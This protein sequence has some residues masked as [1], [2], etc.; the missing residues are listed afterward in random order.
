M[1]PMKGSGQHYLL[2]CPGSPTIHQNTKTTFEVECFNTDDAQIM[3]VDIYTPSAVRHLFTEQ[4]QYI[5]SW[6]HEEMQ[7][8]QLR[9]IKGSKIT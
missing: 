2:H 9:D 5:P 4:F 8:I 1:N 7:N 3:N 6:K